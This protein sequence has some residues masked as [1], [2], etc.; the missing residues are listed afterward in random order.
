MLAE[1]VKIVIGNKVGKVQN[2]F[3][4]GHQYILDGMLIAHKIMKYLRKKKDRCINF[5]VDFEKSYDSIEWG[6]W[7]NIISRM[8]FEEPLCKWVRACLVSSFTSILVNDSP[9]KKF[10]MKRSVRQGDSLSPLHFILAAS[11][12]EVMVLH[13]YYDKT[14]FSSIME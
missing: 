3:I 6:F 9:T 14:L 5:K 11:E 1:S 13:L 8:R 7:N 10:N 4:E 12:N 2:E